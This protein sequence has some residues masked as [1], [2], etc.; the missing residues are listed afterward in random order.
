[1]G[2][3]VNRMQKTKQQLERDEELTNLLNRL[4]NKEKSNEKLT[5]IE[6]ALKDLLILRLDSPIPVASIREKFID[7][8]I[9]LFENNLKNS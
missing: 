1:M 2:S 9:K 4:K 6:N 3:G 5:D 8:A 7:P